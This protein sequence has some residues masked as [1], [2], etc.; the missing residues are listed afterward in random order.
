M[1]AS[2]LTI[3][4]ATEEHSTFLARVVLSASRSQLKRGPFD[5]ALRVEEE[6]VLDILEWMVLSE[7][8]TSLH[9]TKFLVAEIDGEPVG[10]LAAFDP[11]DEDLLP[12]GAAMTDAYAGLGYDETELQAAI[13][14]V[15]AMSRC[16]PPAKPGSWTIEWVGVE[17]NYRGLGVCGQLLREA[18]ANGAKRGL[19]TT[20]VSTYLGNS[21]ALSAYK[22]AGY[23]VDSKRHDERFQ[24]LLGVPGMV[25]M[26][27]DLQQQ[28]SPVLPAIV[29]RLKLVV[30]H[31][32]YPL[33][34]VPI[35][36]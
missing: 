9:F 34:A 31:A 13:A 26:R 17:K 22:S 10:A 3:G 35:P 1:P 18:L 24:A 32:S 36:W 7:L 8:V 12:V 2:N 16:I 33:S 27:R 20:Q 28:A 21:S 25:T 23:E 4:P 11:G 19:K 6:E 14:R 30:I 29:G 5:I 15:E